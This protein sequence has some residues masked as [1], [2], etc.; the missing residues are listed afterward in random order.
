M[1]TRYLKPGVRDS[2]RIDALDAPSET[3]YYRLVVTVD[4]FGRFD[5]RPSMVKAHCFPIKDAITPRHVAD[6]LVRLAQED[7]IQLY[8]A[9]GKPYLQMTRWDNKPRAA[10]SHYPD[11][12]DKCA[13]VRTDAR[14]PRAPAPVTETGT[15]TETDKGGK[16]PAPAPA[17]S[18]PRAP[19]SKRKPS[20]GPFDA[21]TISLPAVV[22]RPDWQRWCADRKLRG[23]A[24]TEE[25]A[26]LQLIKLVKLAREGH[27]AKAV[28]D[29]SIEG[30]YQG[31]FPP[32]VNGQ[33]PA[34]DKEWHQTPDGVI[35]RAKELGIPFPDELKQDFYKRDASYSEWRA[36]RD[37]VKAADAQSDHPQGEH[38]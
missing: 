3:L 25:A 37:N 29:N 11:P 7:L 12:P 2:E 23:K 31:L 24:I 38:T 35:K 32:K 21:A 14:N 5:A 16:P 9:D 20:A 19:A 6:M 4:D 10:A 18:Q 8:E 33:A 13:Q 17:P 36:F 28:I 1:P 27:T 22:Q 15:G 26:R 30:G 34:P